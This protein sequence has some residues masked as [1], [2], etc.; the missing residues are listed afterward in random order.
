MNPDALAYEN[1]RVLDMVQAMI[2]KITPNM[3]A[4][5]IETDHEGERVDIHF[6]MVAVDPLDRQE[7]EE[8]AFDMDN[9]SEARAHIESHVT[10]T[11]DWVEDWPGREHRLLYSLPRLH[12]R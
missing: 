4:I 7:M 2:G 10:V 12:L 9:L 5:S 1:A 8:I 11:D 6:A 3:R